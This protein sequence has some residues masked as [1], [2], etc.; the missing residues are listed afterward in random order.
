MSPQKNS[1]GVCQFCGTQQTL[2]RLDSDRRAALYSRAEHFRRANEYDKAITG[3]G[4]RIE[5][6]LPGIVVMPA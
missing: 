6:S 3:R 5:I 2:P 1:V 4:T